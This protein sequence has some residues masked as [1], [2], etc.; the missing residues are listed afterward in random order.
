MFDAQTVF[1]D[2]NSSL[3]QELIV[4]KYCASCYPGN[5]IKIHVGGKC[6]Y[7]SHMFYL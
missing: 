4:E 1:F 5:A 2:L 7:T 3:K 6:R